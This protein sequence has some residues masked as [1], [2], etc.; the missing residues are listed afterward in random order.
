MNWGKIFQK[1]IEWSFSLLFLLV[2][3]IMTPWNYELFEYNKM[4]LVY[5][6]TVVIAGAWLARMILVKRILFRRTPFD[7]PLLL[8][9]LSQI[10]STVFSIDRHTSIWGYYSRFH[11]GLLSTISYILLYYALTANLEKKQIITLLKWLL[12]SAGV[13]SFYGVLEHFG[14]DAKYWVQDVQN[15]VFST[16]GQP[17]WLAAW[18]AIILP[19]PLSFILQNKL[20]NKTLVIIYSLLLITYTLSLIFT[21]SRS[22]ISSAFLGLVV[23]GFFFALPKVLTVR[24][25]LLIPLAGA[26][27]IIVFAVGFWGAKSLF[28]N[29]INDFSY[30]FGLSDKADI[31]VHMV[32]EPGS[33]SGDIRKVVWRGAFKIFQAYP[34]FGSG[35][36]TFAYSYYQFRPLEHNYLS[37]WD[38]LYNK[39]HNEYFN[40]LATTGIV[41]FGT[42]MLLIGWVVVWNIKYLIGNR[43]YIL[44]KERDKSIINNTYYLLLIAIFSGWLTILITNFFGFSVVPVA[45]CFYLF[46]A[47]SYLLILPEEKET[48]IRNLKS[49]V[50]NRSQKAGLIILVLAGSYFLLSIIKLW[51]A[52]TLF[53]QGQRLNKQS[54]FALALDSLKNAVNINPQEPIYRDEL[55]WTE[56]NLAVLSMSQKQQ[57]LA[58]NFAQNS[59]AQSD[60]ALAISPFNLNFVK[61]RVKI[62]LKLAEIDQSYYQDA[63]NTLSHA[64]ELAPTDP[65][66]RYNL[67]LIYYQVGEKQ[68]AVETLETTLL[69]KP[70]YPEPAAAL[71]AIKKE[72]GK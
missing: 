61:T 8:F 56:A 37:E 28:R 5:F 46:P 9:L 44:S 55:S 31:P 71:S 43:E 3:L 63:L 49:E 48:E 10:L 24:K 53:A 32:Y 36:E 22:G 69:M 68:K 14:I 34:L 29:S 12:A 54:Y 45:L 25:Q 72:L 18:L 39:A 4:M 64:I 60:K 67:G 13:V 20:K 50:L 59:F 15:R 66:L 19:F 33:S 23:F 70:G 65:K 40:F 17:N 62:Y 26:F 7:L 11:G 21:Q 41:G 51:Y 1:V 30:V 16:L 47:V 6:L 52:D 27:L 35:V 57:D 42:Y 38:F 58:I 2:P